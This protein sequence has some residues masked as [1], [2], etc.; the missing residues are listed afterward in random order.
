MIK[1]LKILS[2][3]LLPILIG[4]A[5]YVSNNEYKNVRL[6]KYSISI[7]NSD[8]LQFITKEIIEEWLFSD[9]CATPIGISMDGVLVD[10]LENYICRMNFVD[11]VNI[12]KTILGELRINIEQAKPIARIFSETGDN[13]YIDKRGRTH[14]PTLGYSAPVTL[15][16]C[17][18]LIFSTIK[19]YYD[20]TKKNNENYFFLDKLFNFVRYVNMDVFWNSQITSINITGSGVIEII[21]RIGNQEILLC[22]T[23]NMEKFAEKLNNLKL[24]YDKQLPKSGWGTYSKIDL[25][26]DN[27]IICK[28]AGPLKTMPNNTNDEHKN[29]IINATH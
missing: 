25:R 12:Y 1:L 21:P 19:N 7:T 11:R 5:I 18:T 28:K 22:D 23:Y 15:V 17:D 26:F 13:F 24:F 2:V 3:I 14:I 6:E 9:E 29:N 20:D 8:S 10:S 4:I 16:T 27:L